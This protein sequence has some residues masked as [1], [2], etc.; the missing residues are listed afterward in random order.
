M[1]RRYERK[2]T[3]ELTITPFDILEQPEY[4]E[5]RKHLLKRESTSLSDLN[6][7][8]RAL[9]R[10]MQTHGVHVFTDKL[11]VPGVLTSPLFSRWKRSINVFL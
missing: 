11:I 9:N 4:L 3:I 5:L 1:T 8:M 6:E 10:A 2:F 7:L